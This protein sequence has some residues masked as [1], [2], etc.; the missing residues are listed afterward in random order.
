MDKPERRRG[1]DRRAHPRG[2]RR[3]GDQ[4]G[5]GPL[6]FL[7]TREPEHLLFWEAFLLER[8][9][10]VVPCAGA[11]PALEL[12]GALRPELIVA[13]ARDIAILR[14][15]LPGGRRG[16]AVPLVELVSSPNLVEPV[17][18]AIRRALRAQMNAAQVAEQSIREEA[19]S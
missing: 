11:G 12:F 9:F 5:Y 10:A 18:Q 14:D 7:V 16:T 2:G 15:R 3:P 4:P 6:V 13:S 19:H 1:G 8:K 17:L